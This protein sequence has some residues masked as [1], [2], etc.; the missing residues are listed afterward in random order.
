[1]YG[2]W[3]AA[4]IPSTR[5]STPARGIGII[6]TPAPPSGGSGTQR[7]RHRLR[8]HQLLESVPGPIAQQARTL[9]TDGSRGHLEYP[10][11]LGIDAQLRVH[12]PF[13]QA[14]GGAGRGHGVRNPRAHRLVQ[15]GRRYVVGLLEEGAVQRVRLVEDHQHAQHPLMQHA[16][17]CNFAA[18]NEALDQDEA[19]LFRIAELAQHRLDAPART[20]QRLDMIGANH[21]AAGG[22]RQRLG[23]AGEVQTRHLRREWRGQIDTPV[24]GYRNTGRGE[25]GSCKVLAPRQDHC[26]HGVVRQAQDLG[27]A[28]CELHGGIITSH[29]CGETPHGSRREQRREGGFGTLQVDMQALCDFADQ[30]VLALG[31]NEDGRPELLGGTNVGGDPV[32]AVWGDQQDARAPRHG[33]PGEIRLRHIPR[34]RHRRHHR[35]RFRR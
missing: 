14:I 34:Q 25:S 23:H 8:Q 21:A 11:A 15:P 18:G 22:K 33:A 13:A 10:D 17:Q 4:S 6:S 12:R 24:L 32:A 29:N 30:G 9:A 20:L 16:F 35:C 1:M 2:T 31:G 3:L 5:R 27:H 19:A 26:I 28:A 7:T